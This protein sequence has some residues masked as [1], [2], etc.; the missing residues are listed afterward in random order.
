MD[1]AAH[2]IHNDFYRNYCRSAEGVPSLYILRAVEETVED[3]CALQRDVETMTNKA[4]EGQRAIADNH[5][6]KLIDES[7]D[8]V[9][10]LESIESDLRTLYE[11]LEQ[12]RQSAI[13]DNQLTGDHEDSVVTEYE[14]AMELVSDWY[15]ANRDFR[16][17][18]MEHDADFDEPAGQSYGTAE[19]LINALN[20]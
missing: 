18:V 9:D 14:R 7:G 13:N 11:I 20:T 5:G 16:W 1:S 15:A 8:M 10:A 6:D 2:D 3:L 12:K 19:E 4:R 17:A